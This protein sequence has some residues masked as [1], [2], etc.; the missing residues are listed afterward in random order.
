MTSKAFILAVQSPDGQ[1][2]VSLTGGAAS[3][4]ED[5]YAAIA[6]EFGLKSAADCAVYRDQRRTELIQATRLKSLASLGLKHGDRVFMVPKTTAGAQGGS[7]AAGSSDK[8]STSGLGSS[9]SSSSARE[10]GFKVPPAVLVED[11][12]DRILAKQEGKIE[13]A[14]D[15]LHCQHNANSQCVHCIPLDPFD[16]KY[17]QEKQIKF[18]SFHSYL[19]KISGGMSRGK[20]A[21]LRNL[22]CRVVH[23]ARCSHQPYPQGICSKCQPSAVTLNRQPWR[24]VDAIMFENSQLVD[25]FLTFWRESGAQRCGWLYG[26]YEVYPE[27]PLGI[28][29]VIC[30]IYEP[31]QESSRDHI[32]ILPDP[33]EELVEELASKLGLVRVGWIFTDL[34][35]L[36]D[37]KV[38][39]Y[40]GVD[41]H[42]LS[43]QEIITAAAYQNQFPNKCQLT[44]EKVFGSKFVTVCVTGNSEHEIHMEGYQVS[45][46]CMALVRDGVLVPTKDAPEL[47]YVRESTE[48]NY[49][50]DVFFMEK[51]EYGNEIKKLGRPLP[52]EYLLTDVPVTTPKEPL[53]TFSLL[54]EK[55]TF[56]VENRLLESSI[57]DF[58]SFAG[59]IT[60]FRSAEFFD[61]IAD[62]HVLIFMATLDIMP[63]RE[64]MGPLLEAVRTSNREAAR[65]WSYLDHWGQ[66]QALA[67]A[68]TMS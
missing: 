45:N 39:S 66:V 7:K 44:E 5:L 11:E 12:V 47:A 13:R 55:Q 43:A 51:D 23:T 1:K 30:T 3:K 38:K 27:V 56:P 16:E 63:L 58:N 28:K 29:A 34:V 19:R 59:Y 48:N 67:Q 2:R 61:A 53:A 26:R 8:Q 60:Q 32:R 24:H 31:P 54:K 4:T 41:T 6:K 25:R 52:V 42:F 21:P 57:Q 35:P 62:F 9:S 33:K 18:L 17:L 36:A 40:R 20:F 50:P 65:E 22:C 15:N 10:N 37:G 68:T 14:R 46:Q 64:Y 49:V